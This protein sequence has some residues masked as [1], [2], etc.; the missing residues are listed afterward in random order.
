MPAGGSQ[1]Q[2]VMIMKR[3]LMAAVLLTACAATTYAREDRFQDEY[4]RDTTVFRAG[5]ESLG[6]PSY[7]DR[8]AWDKFFGQ[9]REQFISNGEKYLGYRYEYVPAS[10]YLNFETGGDRSSFKADYEAR[11][12]LVSMMFAELA[13][14]KGRFLPGI[15]DG[16]WYFS[17]KISWVH[18]QHAKRK[19]TRRSLGDP[20]E[21]IIGI[22]SSFIGVDVAL[23][24]HFFR[25][26]WNRVDS[27]ISRAARQ[28]LD[29]HIINPYLDERLTDSNWWLGMTPGMP[30]INWCPWINFNSIFV[31][32][33][34][35]EDQAVLNSA[36]R[37]AFLS[38]DNYMNYLRPDGGC[39]EGPSYWPEAAGKVFDFVALLKKASAGRF[40]L[41]G[42]DRLG[43]MAGYIADI[44]IGDNWVV[45]HADGVARLFPSPHPTMLYRFGRMFGLERLCNMGL[46]YFDGK[47]GG[48][49]FN[50]FE[51]MSLIPEMQ[52]AAKPS[53]V[54]RG[55]GDAWYPDN[56]VAV[57]R[58]GPWY[59]FTLGHNNYAGPRNDTHNHDDVGEFVLF[60]DNMPVFVDMGKATPTNGTYD[61][62]RYTFFH[63]M[64]SSHNVPV[65]NGR[66]QGEGAD[67]KASGVK[68]NLR[69]GTVSMDISGAYGKEAA[70]SRWTRTCR[71][72]GSGFSLVEDYLLRERCGRD[73][74]R[75]MTRG[76]VETVRPGVLHLRVANF[77][78]TKSHTI[79]MTY[80]ADLELT[81]MSIPLSDP[82]FSR[83]WG[84]E[85]KQLVFQGGKDA[86]L[87]SKKTFRV[88]A[89]R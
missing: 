20:D 67:R 43:R 12:A 28:A 34:V 42:W 29:K 59:M 16:V 44:Y 87:A 83:V 69:K 9:Y 74:F 77:D 53:A 39:D 30:I 51:C 33:L 38:L 37:R 19:S 3:L 73:M 79:E 24:Y 25:D 88:R 82:V 2:I 14:G 57:V 10:V 5:G 4:S 46:E 22:T 8:A 85:L 64:S 80:P 56:E 72:D 41:T 52:A 63:I 11:E 78:G 81:V 65:I 58:R 40:D 76:E 84:P 13:E 54:E 61:K 70:V 62:E 86:P 32:L 27:S 66:G 45:S 15:I 50:R 71:L 49:V 60:Y 55:F 31:F 17:E 21:E 68:C 36:L 18:P 23:A 6:Y 47:C 75:F 89:V 48:D 1:I 26:E 7:H 35:E